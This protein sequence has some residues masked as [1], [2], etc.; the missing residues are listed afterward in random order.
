MTNNTEI[1][2][3]LLASLEAK[4]EACAVAEADSRRE[5]VQM[6]GA[7]A[8]VSD[9]AQQRENT[10]RWA[11]KNLAYNVAAQEVRAL[12]QAAELSLKFPAYAGDVVE[13][14][15]ALKY[16]AGQA[17]AVTTN[18]VGS[19]FVGHKVTQTAYNQIIAR[20]NDNLKKG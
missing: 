13:H 11:G 9:L 16:D 10:A 8:D 4:R 18:I 2:T 15:I 7:G 6:V 17:Q 1:L 20:L 14:L 12:I 3:N 5:W 19:A